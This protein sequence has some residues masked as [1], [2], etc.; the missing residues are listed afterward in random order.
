MAGGAWGK[1][2][3]GA[4]GSADSAC[5]GREEHEVFEELKDMQ[6]VERAVAA[7]QG[8]EEDGPGHKG[9]LKTGG[10][11]LLSQGTGVIMG[12][13]WGGHFSGRLCL[14]ALWNMN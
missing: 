10:R 13:I 3:T 11:T 7:A 1:G 4:P 6:C 5:K 9:V 2:E 12:R 8:G 14:A